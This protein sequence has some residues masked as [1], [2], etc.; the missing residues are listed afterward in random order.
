MC[1]WKILLH[2]KCLIFQRYVELL[3][4][5]NVKYKYLTRLDCL[6][7]RNQFKQQISDTHE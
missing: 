3:Y 6:E 7:T 5:R 4:K 1:N 2:K